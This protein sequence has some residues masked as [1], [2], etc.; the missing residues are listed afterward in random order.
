MDEDKGCMTYYLKWVLSLTLILTIFMG[1]VYLDYRLTGEIL[2]NS[3]YI[4][5]F[6]G[7]VICLGIELYLGQNISRKL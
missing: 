1:F 7:F 3:F 6:M 4:S 5:G 2:L